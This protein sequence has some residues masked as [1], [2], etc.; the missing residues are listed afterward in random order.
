MKMLLAGPGTGKTTRIKEI[1]R[2][3]NGSSFLILSFTT[4]TIRDLLDGFRAEKAVINEGNCMTLHAFALKTVGHSSE[5]ILD[6]MDETAAEKCAKKYNTSLDDFCRVFDCMTFN[7]MIQEATAFIRDNEIAA[8]GLISRDTILIVDEFQDFNQLERGL[9]AQLVLHANET[10]ILGDDDQCIYEFKNANVEGI[11][12]LFKKKTVEKIKHDNICYRCPDEVVSAMNRLI[13][14]NHAR[15]PKELKPSGKSGDLRIRQFRTQNQTGS[16]V[17]TEIRRIRGVDQSASVMILSPNRYALMP[18]I[19]ALGNDGLEFANLLKH[20]VDRN[21]TYLVWEVKCLL[22]PNARHRML[23]LLFLG[24]AMKIG[25]E[26]ERE[27]I[28]TN[29]DE[30]WR[31]VLDTARQKSGLNSRFLSLA[32]AGVGLDDLRAEPRYSKIFAAIPDFEQMDAAQVVD[33]LSASLSSVS[34]FDRHGVNVLT[35]HKSKGLQADYVFI[36]GVVEGMLPNTLG[37]LDDI[38]D[39][40]RLLYVGMS[41]AL[42]ALYLVSTVNWQGAVIYKFD[43]SQFKYDHVS[44]EYVSKASSF[45]SELKEVS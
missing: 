43:K 23:Y 40:R 19:E 9:I 26:I 28:A 14:N 3:Y 33:R 34:Q 2:A 31:A 4:A 36:V 15:I 16:G 13:K 41:R 22:S 10:Y 29:I 17:V 30:A 6:E 35:I 38:E 42:K 18:I 8:D 44:K 5:C 24:Q 21:L 37:G 25:F 7:Q 27:A 1:V 39:Q 11:Q 20:E 32:V 45:I 12:S